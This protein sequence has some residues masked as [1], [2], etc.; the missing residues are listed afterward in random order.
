[1]TTEIEQLLAERACERL[2]VEYCRRVDY[3]EADRIADLFVADGTW[4]GVDLVLDGQDEI[5]RWFARR[6]ALDRRVS[7]HVCTNV[8]ITLDGPDRADVLSYLINYRFDRDEGDRR[9]PVPADVP[10]FVGECRDQ[11]VRT[12]DGWRFAARTVSVA[13]VRSRRPR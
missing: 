11:L 10:K 13:F 9:M 1:M 5:R 8:G 7:R 4:T 6:A 3:G 2:L 12:P